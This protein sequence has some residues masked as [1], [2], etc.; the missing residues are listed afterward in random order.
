MTFLQLCQ[1]VRQECGVSGT[2][3]SSVV[4][5]TGEMRRIVDWVNSSY[6]DIQL[7]RP[8]WNWLRADFSFNTTIN[9]GD[10]TPAQAGIAT[11]FSQWDVD[12]IK[13]Y[14]TS[15]GI[16]NEFALG[17]LLY[18]RFRGVY[19]TGSQ[20]SGTPIV[21]SIAPDRQLLLGAKPDA[22]FTVSGQYWKTPQ[23]LTVDADTPEMP[24][25]YHLYI[26]WK[27]LEMYAFYESAAEVM[28]KAEKY[29]RTYKNRLEQNQL[30]DIAMAAPLV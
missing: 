24:A 7:S 16:S 17:E 22:V 8:N 23:A 15:L 5:Q 4:S 29:M 14:R 30:P 13:S 6:E 27:A 19:L 26:V 25:E 9:D 21:F 3:P 12:T 18:S 20:P 10:Y 1:R 11:R 2:G 28:A